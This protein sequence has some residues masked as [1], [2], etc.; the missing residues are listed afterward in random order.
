MMQEGPKAAQASQRRA[1]QLDGLRAFAV[2]LVLWAHSGKVEIPLSGYHGVLLFF[3]ISGFLISRILLSARVAIAEPTGR[4]PVLR[5]FYARRFLRIFPI[6]YAVLLLVALSGAAHI[7]SGLPWHLTYL[8][9]W[10][11]CYRGMP[12]LAHA[13]HFWSLSVEEQFYIFWPWFVL[14]LPFRAVPWAAVTMIVAAPV[15][16]YVIALTGVSDLAIWLSTPAVLDALG[17]GCLLA[18]LWERPHFADQIIRWAL[19]GGLLLVGLEKL[20]HLLVVPKPLACAINNVGWMVICMWLVHRAARGQKTWFG[21]VLRARPLTYIGQISYGIYLMHFFV[22][23]VIARL[24]QHFHLQT[25]WAIQRGLPQFFLVALVST[26]VAA[27]SW[28]YFEGPLNS[29]KRY[30]PY[31]E[32][33]QA[34]Q[35]QAE[36]LVH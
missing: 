14:L 19:A 26:G 1:V 18:Y 5:A 32:A 4:W 20:T 24:G 35:H 6:Y 27:L 8:S 2:L 33:E 34:P 9:N 29:L 15:Y 22:V 36:M 25:A 28:R 12:E 13:G 11:F 3:V 7:R 23:P 30:F 10:Y 16:R 17:M 21:R 31:I